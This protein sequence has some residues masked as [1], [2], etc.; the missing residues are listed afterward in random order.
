M[1][2]LT[3]SDDLWFALDTKNSPMHMLMVNIYAPADARKKKMNLDTIKRF[4]GAR[5]D[6]L[7]LR[8]KLVTVPFNMDYP[9][10]VED[11]DFSLDRHIFDSSLKTPLNWDRF[12]NIL[13]NLSETSLDRS[14]PM[15]EMHLVTGL[16]R[17]KGLPSGTYA[18]ILKVHHA[19]FD[20]TNLFKLLS[21]LHSE[22]SESNTI[23]TVAKSEPRIPSRV[24]LMAMGVWN[25]YA[26]VWRGSWRI[27]KNLPTFYKA[28]KASSSNKTQQDNKTKPPSTR[29]SARIKS[30]RRVFDSVEIPLSE[31]NAIRRKVDGAT[32]NDAALTLVG[33][34]VRRFLT[35][36][37]ELP[38][39]PLLVPCPVSAHQ[40]DESQETGNKG[41][42]MLVDLFTNV[43]DPMQRMKLTNESTRRAKEKIRQLGAAN[44]AEIVD[45]LPT[46]LLSAGMDLIT[47]TRFAETINVGSKIG[48][49]I[50]I[51]NVPGSRK[52]LYLDGDRLLTTLGVGFLAD[53]AGLLLA[54][55]SYEDTL[56][57]QFTSTP[58]AMPDPEFFRK[59][60]ENSFT[61]MCKFK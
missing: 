49:G 27:G 17:V 38:K 6:T 29:F 42:I 58:E 23:D 24:G 50:G 20:G 2:Q 54:I 43:A 3:G 40:A 46:N 18:L 14:K 22:E 37:G 61:E 5:I 33:G 1:R 31:I 4:I 13:Q 8:D 55:T 60:I 47:Q 56:Q 32:V 12:L 45:I 25:N 15:W 16:G 36:Y 53:G 28:A 34:A 35:E 11:Q 52:P 59:C 48:S 9:Y 21:K 7:P 10:W 26:R 57:V 30:R 51:T 44:V 39:D 19:Q 41:T